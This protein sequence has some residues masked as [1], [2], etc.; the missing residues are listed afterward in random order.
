MADRRKIRKTSDASCQ[1]ERRYITQIQL[2][3]KLEKAKPQRQEKDQW[4]QTV[5]RLVECLPS[6]SEAQGAVLSI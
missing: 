6:R 1:V 3:D 4:L 5:A 2:F